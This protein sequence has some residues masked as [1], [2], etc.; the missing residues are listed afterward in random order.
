MAQWFPLVWAILALVFIV[1]EIFTV[2]F[3]I[4]CFGVGA[5]AAAIVALMG[6]STIGQML[7]FV[8]VSAIAVVTIRPIAARV[9]GHGENHVGIDR[10]LHQV[11]VVTHTIE[12]LKA[13]GRVRVEREEWLADSVEDARVA[14]GTKVEVIA[15]EGTRL[16]V[17]PLG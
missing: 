11:A 10:V 2:G 1:A 8:I 13:Q 14:V 16:K 15:V 3:F 7:V 5:A 12:P 6:F 17:R 4:I 9:S